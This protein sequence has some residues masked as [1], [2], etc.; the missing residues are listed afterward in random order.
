MRIPYHTRARDRSFFS[1]DLI[2][3]VEICYLYGPAQ[4]HPIETLQIYG[5]NPR[6]TGLD[7]IPV[8]PS[9]IQT[10]WGKEIHQSQSYNYLGAL[11]RWSVGM[12]SSVWLIL[13]S[14]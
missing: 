3:P 4:Y 13:F 12:F 8:S 6:T 14:C 11:S 1:A 10:N 9:R 7:S 2:P 5:M